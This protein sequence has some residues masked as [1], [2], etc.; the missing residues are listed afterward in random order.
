MRNWT[1]SSARQWIIKVNS[2][3]ESFGLKYC[4]ACDFLKITVSYAKS[5]K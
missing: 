2:R 5:M 1:D 4:S 3:K